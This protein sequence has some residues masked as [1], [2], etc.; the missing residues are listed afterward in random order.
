MAHEIA[1]RTHKRTI[2]CPV[3]HSHGA[4]IHHDIRSSLL[5]SCQRCRHEWQI[6]PAEEPLDVDCAI[7]P[8]ALKGG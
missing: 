8:N 2:E 3:C 4:D 5:Y 7:S 6:D 1:D